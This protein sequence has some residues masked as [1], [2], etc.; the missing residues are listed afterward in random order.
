MTVR[1]MVMAARLG[2]TV[3]LLLGVCWW[4]GLAVPLHAHMA[5]GGLLVASLWGL[6]LVA[7]GTVRGLALAG[8]V[9]GA[10]VPLLGMMQ[11]HL[12][13][14][15]G[16]AVLHLLHAGSGLAAITLAEMLGARL[17]RR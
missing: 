10:L 9:V 2:G 8:V 1:L 3:A 13:F 11:L 7:R 4:W 6:A 12:N 5:A 17:R 16:Q 14:G 15:A